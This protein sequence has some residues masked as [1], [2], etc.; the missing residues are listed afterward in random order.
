[1]KTI[2]GSAPDGACD[3]ALPVAA[4][5]LSR[6]L[7]M[8]AR[9]LGG[10]EFPE[11]R[12]GAI[13]ARSPIYEITRPPIYEIALNVACDDC[14]AACVTRAEA[15][16]HAAKL[17]REHPE[18]GRFRWLARRD[19]AGV[20]GVARISMPRGHRDDKHVLTAA[21]KPVV[22]PDGHPLDLPGGLPPWGIGSA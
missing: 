12:D 16:G 5:G 13:S 8:P 10:V 22:P 6:A 19:D 18:R 1:M 2:L 3:A 15:E 17:N 4:L 11:A 21:D 20:W 9:T 7:V 14:Y